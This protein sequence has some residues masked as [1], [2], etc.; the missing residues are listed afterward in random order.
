MEVSPILL[1][2]K[3]K[4]TRNIYIHIYIVIE[5]NFVESYNID[6]IL[7]Q[8]SIDIHKKTENTNNTFMCDV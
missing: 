2:E 8:E 7:I 3:Y 4:S 5:V 1:L 6:T